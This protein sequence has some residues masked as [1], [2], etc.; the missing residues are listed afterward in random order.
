VAQAS[1]LSPPDFDGD[2]K[3]D[4]AVYQIGTG[5]WT[6]IAS[7]TG[8]QVSL[9]TFGGGGRFAPVPAD[10]DGDGKAD[11]ALYRKRKGKWR[12]KLFDDGSDVELHR[13]RR[14]WLA[15]H[16]RRF[17]RRRQGGRRGVPGSPPAAGVTTARRPA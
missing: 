14:H 16:A 8:L 13:D 11:Q 15:R 12:F 2:G 7:S 17:R 5:A 10:Y 6:Y 4:V 3:A 1:S 9:G